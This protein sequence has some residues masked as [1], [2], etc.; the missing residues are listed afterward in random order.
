MTRSKV[1]IWL[2]S[3][4]V[5]QFLILSGMLVKAAMPLWTGTEIRVKT[6]PVDPRS[7]FRGNYALLNYDISQLPDHVFGDSSSIRLGEIVYVSLTPDEQGLYRFKD[8]SL[9]QPDGG[10]FLR[11]RIVDNYPPYQVMYGI[12]AFFAPKTTAVQLEKD[13]RNGGVAVLMVTDS[14]RVAL[15]DVVPEIPEQ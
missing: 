13:L 5:L 15:R 8:A 9:D 10:I 2:A 4:I 14:G 1:V 6:V 12:E 3:A 11:G 7:L